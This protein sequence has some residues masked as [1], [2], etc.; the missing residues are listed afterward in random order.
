MPIKIAWDD[1]AH[2]ILLEIVSGVYTMQDYQV[3]IDEAARR[4]RLEDHVVH[5]ISDFR[6]A[7]PTPSDALNGALYAEKHMAP[8]QGIVVFV[9][10]NG[11]LQAFINVT[12]KAGLRTARHL[13]TT[14]TIEAA[15][16]IIADKGADFDA[17]Y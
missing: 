15:Y 13:Y 9:G 8:N 3:M 12:Q 1:P 2:T 14:P 16:Q 10:V 17:G 11:L 6:N 5:I 7:G 4:L